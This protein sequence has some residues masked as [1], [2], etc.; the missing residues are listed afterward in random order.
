MVIDE[1]Y[2]RDVEEA[3][4]L[5]EI[6]RFCIRSYFL[7]KTPENKVLAYTL[8]RNKEDGRS[9]NVVNDPVSAAKKW[10]NSIK[11]SAYMR[12]LTRRYAVAD[13]NGDITTD[14]L[15]GIEDKEAVIKMYK[16]ILD[17]TS[18][19][20]LKVNLLDKIAGLRGYK[21]DNSLSTSNVVFFLPLRCR[22]CVH[23]QA[24]TKSS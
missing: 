9:Q 11:V 23:Y 18:D 3:S 1:A 8:S 13:D 6:E 5:S 19:D 16:R 15:S 17:S 14:I 10:F 24:F 21:K 4:P 2:Q 22:D 7:A 20:K 12:I